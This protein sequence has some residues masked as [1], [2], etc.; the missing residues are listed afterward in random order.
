MKYFG[1]ASP[2]NLH[3]PYF[4]YH[5]LAQKLFSLEKILTSLQP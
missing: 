5:L 2:F 3:H 1:E 4:N